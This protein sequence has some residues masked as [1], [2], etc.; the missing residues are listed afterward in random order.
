MRIQKKWHRWATLGA[1]G[2][3]MLAGANVA[4]AVC[5][6]D[7]NGDKEVTVDEIITMVNIANGMATIEACPN[8]D[9]NDDGEVS[10][11]DIISAVNNANNGCPPEPEGGCGDGEPVAPEECDD[12][13]ICIGGNTAGTACEKDEECGLDQPGVCDGGFKIG[14]ACRTDTTCPGS[15]CVRCKTFGGDGCAANCTFETSITF[16]LKPGQTSEVDC[17]PNTSCAKVFGDVVSELPLPLTGQQTVTIGKE[18]DGKIPAVIKAASVDLPK[19]PVGSIACACVRGL[20]VKTCGGTLFTEDGALAGNCSDN[21]PLPVECPT[22][23]PCA[24]VNGPGNAAAGV[25]GCSGLEPVDV[26]LTQDCNG[27]EG[28]LPFPPQIA[29]SGSGPAGSAILLN[30]LQI[31]TQTG[32]CTETFCTDQDPID[33]RGNPVTLPYTT[34]TSTG[35]A[36]NVSNFQGFNIGPESVTGSA[37]S[38]ANLTSA[39]PSLSGANIGGVFSS[40]DAATVGDIVVT[41]NQVAQ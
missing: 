5:T 36:F 31:G 24:F 35:T 26:T 14:S 23:R 34:G 8:A 41:N 38:C 3:I 37:F 20:P 12:G 6:G 1:A 15:K 39:S 25:I 33:Q 21:I 28:G 16:T 4:A 17:V 29:L 7:C 10:I 9:G 40:C 18:R 19:I 32:L 30:T 13:G 2:L 11:D 27:E 22:D